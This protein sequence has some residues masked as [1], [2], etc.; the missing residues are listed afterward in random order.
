MIG[1]DKTKTNWRGR[2]RI[3]TILFLPAFSWRPFRNAKG[4][5]KQNETFQKRHHW[6]IYFCVLQYYKS[7]FLTGMSSCRLLAVVCYQIL[8]V[9][10]D[11]SKRHLAESI[12]RWNYIFTSIPSAISSWMKM[13]RIRSS[14]ARISGNTSTNFNH[15]L[16]HCLLDFKGA[17]RLFHTRAESCARWDVRKK[18]IKFYPFPVRRL[19]DNLVEGSDPW[20]NIFIAISSVTSK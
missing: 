20:N 6:L 2:E 13:S 1:L 10:G 12:D 17:L 19:K 11:M 3:G 4:T 5:A 9:S 15:R 14:S 8:S 7:N 18:I 16:F